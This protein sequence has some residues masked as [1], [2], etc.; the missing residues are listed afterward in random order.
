M[1]PYVVTGEVSSVPGAFRVQCGSCSCRGFPD[2]MIFVSMD[3]AKLKLAC[4]K[5]GTSLSE[6]DKQIHSEQDALHNQKLLAVVRAQRTLDCLPHRRDQNRHRVQ[7]NKE[8]ESERF[9]A[10]VTCGCCVFN[11]T[12]VQMKIINGYA[13]ISLTNFLRHMDLLHP[14]TDLFNQTKENFQQVLWQTLHLALY[15]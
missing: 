3:E 15:M 7:Y 13:N 5:Y 9:V 6:H 4:G 12:T 1:A 11:Q 10:S 14:V 8:S 2:G